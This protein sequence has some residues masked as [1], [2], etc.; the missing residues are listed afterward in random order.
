MD[1]DDSSSNINASVVREHLNERLGAGRTPGEAA[2][3]ILFAHDKQLALGALSKRSREEIDE[4]VD[5]WLTES[6]DPDTVAMDRQVAGAYSR[7]L[8]ERVTLDPSSDPL[9]QLD[10]AWR[11]WRS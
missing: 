1:H 5:Q 10:A 7:F 9:G 8:A 6:S 2:G 11:A 4:I 3:E